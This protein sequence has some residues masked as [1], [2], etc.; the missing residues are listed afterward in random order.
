MSPMQHP[1]VYSSKTNDGSPVTIPPNIYMI[2]GG[3]GF[4]D[5]PRTSGL[6][7]WLYSNW[8]EGNVGGVEGE[9][10]YNWD[11]PLRSDQSSVSAGNPYVLISRFANE[12][13]IPAQR[14]TAFWN[15]KGDIS[16]FYLDSLDRLMHK[17]IRFH[18][19]QHPLVSAGLVL[20]VEPF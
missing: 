2:A 4:V 3:T 11:W 18:S 19:S 20:D 14:V 13:D 5:R 9:F 12:D 17:M 10:E 16:L 1:G 8:V 7:G 15:N 6:D